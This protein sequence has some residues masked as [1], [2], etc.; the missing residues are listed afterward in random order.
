MIPEVVAVEK[1]DVMSIT[2]K[3][4]LQERAEGPFWRQANEIAE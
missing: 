4:L 2:V 3:E 1:A